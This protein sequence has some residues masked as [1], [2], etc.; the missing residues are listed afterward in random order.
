MYEDN[1]IAEKKA[2][3]MEVETIEAKFSLPI[4]S[5]AEQVDNNIPV[6]RSYR[7]LIIDDNRSIHED[8]RSIFKRTSSKNI[9]VSEEEAAILGTTPGLPEQQH[10]EID[11]AFQGEEGLEKIRQALSEER[12]YA[13]AFVDI[14]MPPGW[15]GVETIQRIWQE[16]PELQVTICT[17]YSDYSWNNLIER[18]GQTDKLLILK[19][20]FDNIEVRQIVCS[21]VEKWYLSRQVQFKQKK[22]EDMVDNMSKQLCMAGTIQ[23][24]FFP[25]VLPDTENIRWSAALVPLEEVSGDIYDVA[26]IDEHYI[27]FYVADVVGHGMP[28]AILTI[29]LKQ[30]LVMREVIDNKCH[31]FSPSEVMNDLNTKMLEQRLSG[32]PFVT[33]CYCLLNIETLELTYAR[34]GHPYPVLIRRGE[35][36]KK[37]EIRGSLLGVLEQPEYPQ[38]T[39]QL[40]RG[41]KFLLHSDGMLSTINNLDEKENSNFYEE[42]R[43]IEDL[44]ITELVNGLTKLAKER[45]I[46]SYEADDITIVGLEVL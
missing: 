17:A 8:F 41:D 34:S 26:R 21:L 20:P 33:C 3:I 44:N 39:V 10:F 25:T 27:G 37:L 11:S 36:P 43:E 15:D 19:K 6:E 13:M 2:D 4:K 9:D 32:N 1:F 31:V 28:A 46:P 22:L 35:I 16:Y 30:A 24:D 18:F 12:P 45:E 7:I 14:R 29:F 38:Q 42:F 40:Q 23:R 5:E